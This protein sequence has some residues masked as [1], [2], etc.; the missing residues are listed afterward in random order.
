[1]ANHRSI[2]ANGVCNMQVAA[3]S[4]VLLPMDD[5]ANYF[6]GVLSRSDTDVKFTTA[7]FQ[8][9]RTILNHHPFYLQISKNEFAA[10]LLRSLGPRKVR[11]SLV[12]DFFDAVDAD[13]D[14]WL[15]A[16]ELATHLIKVEQENILKRRF[17]LDRLAHPTIGGA[18]LFA[19]SSALS[20]LQSLYIQV[21]GED[22]FPADA[23]KLNC[24]LSLLGSL[25]FV[26]GAF[27]PA[28][29]LS[30]SKQRKAMW[31]K[32][33]SFLASVT[34]LDQVSTLLPIANVQN[35]FIVL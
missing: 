26:W 29:S 13:M 32:I 30:R 21:Q 2:G 35:N 16:E 10:L 1:M 4:D 9:Q 15:S 31:M 7:A 34:T 11:S 27:P 5:D 33:R 18:L 3:L 22:V 8:V 6:D 28:A 23:T 25:M 17:F 12:D 24:W 19:C 20:I 14:G